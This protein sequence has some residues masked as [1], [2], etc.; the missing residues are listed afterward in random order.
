MSIQRIPGFDSIPSNIYPP[1]LETETTQAQQ[2]AEAECAPFF[3]DLAQLTPG[4][5]DHLRQVGLLGQNDD[6]YSIDDK[7]YSSTSIQLLR[8]KHCRYL[9]QVWHRPLKASF[10]SLDSS[11]PW[12]LYWCLHGYDLLTSLLPLSEEKNGGTSA[13]EGETSRTGQ[14]PPP[15]RRRLTNRQ[16]CNM[17]KTLQECWQSYSTQSPPAAMMLM[18]TKSASTSIHDGAVDMDSDGADG[19]DPIYFIK[20]SRDVL[21]EGDGMTAIAEYYCGGFGGGPGQMAHAATTY[22]AIL[23]LCILAT[24]DEDGGHG[25]A[26]EEGKHDSKDEIRKNY[27]GDD[28]DDD[29]DEYTVH[30]SIRA[31]ELLKD[32][33]IPVYR[34]M[35]SLQQQEETGDSHIGGYRMHHDGE[36]DVRATYTIIACAKLLQLLPAGSFLRRPAVFDFCV[37]CQTYE[38]GM[39]G[40]PFSEAH[41]GYTFCAVAALQLLGGLAPS[42]GG[43]TPTSAGV[44]LPALVGWLARR[45]MPFE[46]GFSGRA[47]KL[48]DGC[49]SFWQGGAMAIASR[50][51]ATSLPIDDDEE[52]MDGDP[53]LRQWRSNTGTANN[54]DHGLPFPLLFDVTMLERYILLCAQEVHGGLRDKPSKPRDFYHTCYN[55]SGLSVAQ[56]CSRLVTT[57][58]A[59]EQ[60]EGRGDLVSKT[61]EGYGDA[62]Q[63]LLAPTHPCYNIRVDRV[64]KML[65]KTW[66]G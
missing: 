45:Q 59:M 39:G 16:G 47:N 22:A 58:A 48:V 28:D 8:E 61:N 35:A 6:G 65:N 2:E 33:R 23:S 55:L 24:D 38:G 40:E 17:V 20:H 66:L 63:T 1:L 53:W 60:D 15:R 29:D 12:I 27:D 4:Q 10:V 62:K 21:D 49:Y 46:G 5:L 19:L 31:Y 57:A 44:D 37:S 54:D 25:G 52:T 43:G 26:E 18:N 11:R 9:E 34:W 30:Y 13:G 56:H 64:Q 7:G 32:I 51:I 3:V 50:A 42:R 14:H 41:G 36:V